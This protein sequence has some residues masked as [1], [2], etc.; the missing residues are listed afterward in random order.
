MYK[1]R[2]VVCKV[3]VCGLR[4]LKVLSTALYSYS[5]C[6]F[7]RQEHFCF[8]ITSWKS[9]HTLGHWEKT[10]NTQSYILIL[11]TIN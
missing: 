9:T 6:S 10:I 2:G 8:T 5:K 4:S 1:A 7:T 3:T 11:I